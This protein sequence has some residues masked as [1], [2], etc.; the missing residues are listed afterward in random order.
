MKKKKSKK[1]KHVVDIR[2]IV[3]DVEQMSGEQVRNGLGVL[4]SFGEVRSNEN[5]VT[6]K[7][8]IDQ[9][10]VEAYFIFLYSSLSCQYGGL[11]NFLKILEKH[12]WE[13]ISPPPLFPVGAF[14]PNCFTTFEIS[15]K[16][17]T[18]TMKL[19]MKYCI[20]NDLEFS[21]RN[22]DAIDSEK[23]VKAIR[24]G[25]IVGSFKYCCSECFFTMEYESLTQKL[26]DNMSNLPISYLD[27]SKPVD[28]DGEFQWDDC[29]SFVLFNSHY[30]EI[31]D[32]NP[33]SHLH[34]VDGS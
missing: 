12:G 5:S 33:K 26:I 21:T 13:G 32:S 10:Y 30:I 6:L 16:F 24:D 22:V 34:I 17:N 14:C 18:H 8:K 4:F 31:C 2:S 19:S 3:N 20:D 25:L 28:S 29:I 27:T 11:D 23:I 1:L 7:Q 15:K 9:T